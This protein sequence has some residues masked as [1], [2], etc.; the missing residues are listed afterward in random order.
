MS[1]HALAF[2]MAALVF[3]G[4]GIALGLYMA[5]TDDHSL[6]PVHAH[7]NLLGWVSCAIQGLFHA[8]MR[9]LSSKRIMRWQFIAYVGGVVLMM[10]GLAGV[11]RADERLAMLIAPG[12]MAT[13]A[14]LA[15][16]AWFVLKAFSASRAAEARD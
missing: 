16:F 10:I 5:A 9:D 13:L 15:L 11:L 6:S 4:F 1:T 8:Q 7:L 3:L 14:G 12:T 2:M